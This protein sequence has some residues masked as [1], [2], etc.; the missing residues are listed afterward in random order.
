[1]ETEVKLYWVM[2]ERQ[3]KFIGL[4]IPG[5]TRRLTGLYTVLLGEI[6]RGRPSDLTKLWH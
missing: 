5:A 3:M 1:M 4:G 6:E 2:T